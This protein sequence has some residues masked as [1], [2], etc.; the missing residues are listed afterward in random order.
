MFSSGARLLARVNSEDETGQVWGTL[1]VV[2]GGIM[3]LFSTLVGAFG[4]AFGEL[5]ADAAV[6]NAMTL[7]ALL[8]WVFPLQFFLQETIPGAQRMY[9]LSLY[10][11][12]AKGLYAL[13]LG[14]AA[15][16]WRLDAATSLLLNL[17]AMG[18]GG[19]IVLYLLRPRFRRW[20]RHL[21]DLKRE[22]L[23]YGWFMYVGRVF[24]SPA[25]NL[26]G[27]VLPY[28]GGTT[29][30]ALYAVGGNLTTPMVQASQSIST[31]LY[32]NFSRQPKIKFRLFF[33]NTGILLAV[34]GG[35]LLFA[36][37]L[38]HLSANARYEAAV[39]YMLPL[40]IAGFFQGFYQPLSLFVSAH[41]K[42]K[43]TRQILIAGTAMDITS[44]IVMIYYF[45]TWGAVWQ[46]VISK[47]GW[48]LLYYFNY[49]RTAKLLKMDGIL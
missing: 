37:Q 4:L 14:V 49:R 42:G 16:F 6:R 28:I 41:G 5:Y 24:A 23:E 22:F 33:I 9:E 43:W 27:L 34:G 8:A 32:R 21:P 45:G 18:I 40:V 7:S 36:P 11:L 12:L 10:T 39:P 20:R 44:C 2:T 15:T 30:S 26:V 35:I 38:I 47:G 48:T 31:T 1:I 17:G 46:G 29:A 25:F 3:L 19:I 13:G